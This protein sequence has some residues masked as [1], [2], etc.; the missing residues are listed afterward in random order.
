M[1][2]LETILWKGASCLNGGKGLFFRRGVFF[3]KL[4]GAPW[5]SIGFD[6]GGVFR[7]KLLDGGKATPMHPHY[8]KPWGGYMLQ[9]NRIVREIGFFNFFLLYCRCFFFFFYCLQRAYETL[10]QNLVKF[11]H[12][13]HELR[14]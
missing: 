11:K 8:G 13:S 2:F 10:K 3:C 4:E 7:K 6:G 12:S 5:W 14:S 9:K 1:L